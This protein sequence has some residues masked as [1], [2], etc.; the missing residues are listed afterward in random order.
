MLDKMIYENHLGERFEFGKDGLFANHSDVRDYMWNYDSTNNIISNFNKGVVT[1]SLPFV[2]VVGSDES[3]QEI[4]DKMVEIADKDISEGRK[5]KL[6]VDNSYIRC[7]I[8]GITQTDYLINKRYMKGTVSIVTDDP[9]WRAQTTLHFL[10]NNLSEGSG[11]D[12]PH[13]YPFDYTCSINYMTEFNNPYNN[14]D[15]LLTI[16]GMCSKPA[17]IINDHTYKMNLSLNS[18]EFL[19]IDSINKKIIKTDSVGVESNE[20]DK[21]HKEES[22]FEK[23]KS[24]VNSIYWDGSFGFDLTLISKT[25]TP[26]RE[27]P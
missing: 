6:I 1:K 16:W 23:I 27:V 9:Y 4:K 5:G 17:I 13:A 7:N 14:A 8:I 21:R 18:D 3:A 15:F 22:I 19:T 2:I 20:F 11:I 25:S 12:F 10:K 24:G 26:I